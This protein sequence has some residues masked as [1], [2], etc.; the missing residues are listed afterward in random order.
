MQESGWQ[1]IAGRVGHVGGIESFTL[2][3]RRHYFGF[4]HKQG[5]V[6]SPAIDDAA[7]MAHFASRHMQALY[8]GRLFGLL[9]KTGPR[10]EAFWAEA[11]EWSENAT[12][13][14]GQ[15]E[16]TLA[17]A[18][19]A[20]SVSELGL[21]AQENR[22]AREFMPDALPCML[23]AAAGDGSPDEAEGIQAEIAIVWGREPLPPGREIAEVA[24]ALQARL[25]ALVD[26]AQGNWAQIFSMLKS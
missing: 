2:D 4:D 25:N 7:A 11:V 20:A 3:G 15:P 13:L 18:Q 21:A 1:P 8:R 14:P 23:L 10:D 16:R 22:I 24:R 26:R 6:L 5:L 9:G 17:S 19:L 12:D